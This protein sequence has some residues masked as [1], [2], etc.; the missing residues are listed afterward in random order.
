ME[1]AHRRVGDQIHADQLLQAA[2]STPKRA[3]ISGNDGNTASIENGPIIDNAAS[4]QGRLRRT[5][6]WVG[7]MAAGS[8][9][10]PGSIERRA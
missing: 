4:S 3:P 9:D 2:A 10:G 5:G 7:F 6:R 8:V 1:Q